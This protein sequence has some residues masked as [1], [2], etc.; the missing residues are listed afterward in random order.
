MP[1]QTLADSSY[2]YALFSL[3]DALHPAAQRVAEEAQVILTVPEVVLT[4]TAFL[5]RRA[6][7]VPAVLGF[8]DALVVAQVQLRSV[9]V[10]HLH[11][12]REIMGDYA[13]SRLDFV[14]CCIMA[15]AEQLDITQICTF[16]RRD[17][18]IFRPRH[19]DYLELLP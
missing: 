18:S 9:D 3:H 17:F 5:F 19:C 10:S 4:E 12:A 7:G 14:D 15:L 8:L 1:R 11:R 16:D 2:L 13:D 6:G